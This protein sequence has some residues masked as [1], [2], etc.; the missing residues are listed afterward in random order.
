[1]HLGS[2]TRRQSI[3]RTVDRKQI[4]YKKW[5]KWRHFMGKILQLILTINLERLPVCVC[6]ATKSQWQS[7]VAGEINNSTIHGQ[8]QLCNVIIPFIA[9]QRKS[10]EEM[11]HSSPPR[12]MSSL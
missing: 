10:V 4:N 12:L 7:Q 6:P 9:F 8:Q 2:R 1:M 5:P 3:N 11:V